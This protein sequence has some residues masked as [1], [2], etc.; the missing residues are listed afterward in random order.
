[1][2]TVPD[3]ITLCRFARKERH[4]ELG[5]A[6]RLVE[7]AFRDTRVG[8][9]VDVGDKI[10]MFPTPLKGKRLQRI[11]HDLHLK[12]NGGTG[13]GNQMQRVGDDGGPSGTVTILCR[14][15]TVRIDEIVV[16][17]APAKLAGRVGGI[18]SWDQLVFRVGTILS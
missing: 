18:G 12:L 6:G 2:W 17:F 15:E 10:Q 9:E 7:S 13:C 5:L 1:A 4:G 14:N 3:G 8:Y 11:R 16:D